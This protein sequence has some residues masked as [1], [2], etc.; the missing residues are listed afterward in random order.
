MFYIIVEYI[1]E[2]DYIV[3]ENSIMI[4]MNSQHPIYKVL[5]IK[6]EVCKFYKNYLRMFHF[7]LIDKN[8]SIAIIKIY[9]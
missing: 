7:L 5:Y 2:D 6:R 9:K 8:E 1:R 3:D 4:I